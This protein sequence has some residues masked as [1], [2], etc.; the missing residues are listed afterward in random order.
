MSL[1]QYNV[2]PSFSSDKVLGLCLSLR[3]V[4]MEP[5]SSSMGLG[6]GL[7]AGFFHQVMLFLA[8]KF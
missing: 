7:S 8:K 4:F 3:K 6:S 1:L 2:M 5:H